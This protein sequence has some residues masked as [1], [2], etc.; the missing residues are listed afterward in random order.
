MQTN[1]FDCAAEQLE[2][3]TDL[4]RLEARGTLRL[5]IKQAGL[6]SKTLSLPELG[7]VF[8]KVM[9]GELKLRGIGSP[10]E[11]CGTVI[12]NLKRTESTTEETPNSSI[13]DIFH[14]LGGGA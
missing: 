13:D 4:D 14:R 3:S 11:I 8:E 6:D 5:A 12:Q 10:K 9:P 1:L 2:Q 7:V